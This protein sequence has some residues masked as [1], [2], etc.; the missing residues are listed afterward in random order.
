MTPD[1][2]LRFFSSAA[3]CADVRVRIETPPKSCIVTT[4]VDGLDAIDLFRCQGLAMWIMELLDCALVPTVSV[5]SDDG[6]LILRITAHARSVGPSEGGSSV[7][8]WLLVWL[9]ILACLSCFCAGVWLEASTVERLVSLSTGF[10]RQGLMGGC[11][12]ALWLSSA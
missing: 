4:T 1:D 10:F 7:R 9:L 8:S 5:S 6:S 12:V 2:V 11:R 3:D